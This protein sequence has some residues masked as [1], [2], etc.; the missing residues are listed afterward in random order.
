MIKKFENFDNEQG[1]ETVEY[2][3]STNGW[4]AEQLNNDFRLTDIL[5]E[6]SEIEYEIL[7]GVRG[8]QTG[9]TVIEGL[10]KRLIELSDELISN[11][12]DYD[13]SED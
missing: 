11:L 3:D 2:H 1:T 6:F 4:D 8:S 13:V 12:G 10:A 5:S 9:S 7:N